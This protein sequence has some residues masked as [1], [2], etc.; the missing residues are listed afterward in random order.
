MRFSEYQYPDTQT[1]TDNIRSKISNYYSLDGQ[2]NILAREPN[3]VA[4]TF[5]SEIITCQLPDE[6]ELQF[7]CKYSIDRSYNTYGHQ[8][9]LSYEA[10]VYRHV[11]QR[12]Q[13]SS[14]KFYGVHHNP[15]NEETW[16]IL[17]Y[18]DNSMPVKYLVDLSVLQ[19]AAR[20]LGQFHRFNESLL[21]ESSLQFLNRY[22]DGYYK[23][24]AERTSLFAGHL[25][26]HFP[27]LAN[28]CKDSVSITQLILFSVK[29][30]F[31]LW[32]G[33]QRLSPAAKL[34]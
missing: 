22:D 34:I 20:W 33:S 16:L 27:W 7:I 17:E 25:H 11:L 28:L 4:S 15:M 13:I 8:N 1:L 18:F 32:I 14:P 19:A 24:W 6:S 21:S 3:S 29:G 9:G 31:T 30:R 5:P 23:G 2:I 10:K 12:M 26:Q